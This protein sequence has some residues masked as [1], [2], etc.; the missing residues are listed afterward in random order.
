MRLRRAHS[1][2][3][4]SR[5]ARRKAAF[6]VDAPPDALSA[7]EEG[8]IELYAQQE[9]LREGLARMKMQWTA[10]RRLRHA[11]SW[12][13]L[14]S[15]SRALVRWRA[16]ASAAELRLRVDSGAFVAFAI[17]SLHTWWRVAVG[18]GRVRRAHRSA[19]R[20]HQRVCVA[21]AMEAWRRGGGVT[22]SSLAHRL[23]GRAASVAQLG[24]LRRR[25]DEW[26]EAHASSLLA[27]L[28][29][30]AAYAARTARG[31]Y[32]WL[33][34]L[35][36]WRLAAQSAAAYWRRAAS[37]ALAGWRLRA[38]AAHMAA[39]DERRL[40]AGTTRR[41][42][43]GWRSW[44][45]LRRVACGG[46]SDG[47]PLDELS[48]RRHSTFDMF[49]TPPPPPAWR[50]SLTDGQ[51][52]LRTTA[53]RGRA[54]LAREG[55]RR[56]HSFLEGRVGTA[57]AY[58]LTQRAT[59]HLLKQRVYTWRLHT[60]GD[61]VLHL[62]VGQVLPDG[63]SPRG[64]PSHCGRG[65]CSPQAR[66]PD[67]PGVPP[68]RGAASARRGKHFARLQTSRHTSLAA[69]QR[70]VE[71]RT[72]KLRGQ[73]EYL[74]WVRTARTLAFA[75][76]EWVDA[77]RR[78]RAVQLARHS[79]AIAS[80]Y[81]ALG[82]WV[83]A[84][85]AAR[86]AARRP[87]L[88][89]LLRYFLLA[90]ALRL[91]LTLR[92]WRERVAAA[93][94]GRDAGG[95]GAALLARR[96]VRAWLVRSLR[97][98]SSAAAAG[99]F[100]LRLAML[101]LR[102]SWRALVRHA[103]VAACDGELARFAARCAAAWAAR[104]AVAAWRAATRRR[105]G[106]AAWRDCRRLRRGL[107]AMFDAAGA[108]LL[109]ARG[110][111]ARAALRL[112]AALRRW[113]RQAAVAPPPFV[114]SQR[115]RRVAGALLQ[116]RGAARGARRR[117]ATLVVCRAHFEAHLLQLRL[118]E[119]FVVGRRAAAAA[120][121]AATRRDARCAASF[122]AWRAHGRA[123]VARWGAR[124]LAARVVWT[125][126]VG[127]ALRELGGAAVR[128]RAFRALRMQAL[129][130]FVFA[131]VS[132][133]FAV[134]S[135][136]AAR[137]VEAARR[138]VKG[139]ARATRGGLLAAHAHWRRLVLIPHGRSASVERVRARSVLSACVRALR[140]WH[141]QWCLATVL[142]ARQRTFRLISERRAQT[143][144]RLEQ[145]QRDAFCM[146]VDRVQRWTLSAVSRA[147]CLRLL[148][149]RLLGVLR[150]EASTVAKGVSQLEL[151]L[152]WWVRTN[153]SSLRTA[154]RRRGLRKVAASRTRLH[155]L[156][157]AFDS[158]RRSCESRRRL[159]DAFEGCAAQRLATQR[160]RFLEGMAAA[161]ARGERLLWRCSHAHWRRASLRRG[162]TAARRVAPA[163]WLAT[164]IVHAARGELQR[165]LRF[166]RATG[167]AALS[168][169]LAR[170]KA[171]LK[172]MLALQSAPR[173]LSPHACV[174][175]AERLAMARAML[176]LRAS[177]QLARLR[178]GPT[179]GRPMLVIVPFHALS[180]LFERLHNRL[181]C[182]C[183][184]CTRAAEAFCEVSER[185]VPWHKGLRTE[186]AW[187]H[188]RHNSTA[189]LS[190][191]ALRLR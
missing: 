35:Q 41:A 39:L 45:R 189:I 11:S 136:R 163:R 164:A 127:G 117:E 59:T 180:A 97:A 177:A 9:A 119:W 112:R 21:R 76:C 62:A 115:A 49:A 77:A 52:L 87:V 18:L 61:L 74:F 141:E 170:R 36:Q 30:R 183:A 88:H 12:R 111:G 48:A 152:S 138:A 91:Q 55:M 172:G 99:V 84:C 185:Y 116:W 101:R 60:I 75:M 38:V 179:N 139:R 151:A 129:E 100:A 93:A 130:H 44:A 86:G 159:G 1:P 176:K 156:S 169:R 166:L 7:F 107:D 19:A 20:W 105:R 161:V 56:W 124:R 143:T 17:R 181:I 102:A 158:F 8:V 173:I 25:M 15:M 81:A 80:A 54:R 85:N 126:R 109:T 95:R 40:R 68:S 43:N 187:F 72:H 5:Y 27:T 155:R 13:S 121:A 29:R 188:L 137:A 90:R 37:A 96:A 110:G 22:S 128:A 50:R 149:R 42:L 67:A 147:M 69:M 153:F 4:A 125:V 73:L 123:W 132:S 160:R 186:K 28:G 34:T 103:A 78:W 106:A 92:E 145:R 51:Q 58:E 146:W 47:A 3:K 191:L 190:R 24:Q 33:E 108:A 168:F 162:F 120:A 26:R 154:A 63:V 16:H 184:P 133:R 6:E 65:D 82:A 182:S 79:S 122:Q 134:W 94:T 66:A 171:L 157:A 150:A 142:I 89:T 175:R 23:L 57:V 131:T 14:A 10:A 31:L 165:G 64:E 71:E 118:L 83:D 32:R 98:R 70:S 53:A 114:R 113:G 135:F 46:E 178:S 104:R 148:S 144:G 140:R 174:K 2:G 167:R